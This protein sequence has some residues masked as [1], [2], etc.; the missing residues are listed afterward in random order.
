MLFIRL[1]ICNNYKNKEMR[2]I[3]FLLLMAITVTLAG[4]GGDDPISEEEFRTNELRSQY[5][6]KVLGSWYQERQDDANKVFE[7]LN[8]S[9]DGKLTGYVKW[10]RRT[11]VTVGGEEVWTDWAT[12][13]DGELNGTW[14][15]VWEKGLSWIDLYATL[16]G[17]EYLWYG[18]KFPFHEATEEYLDFESPFWRLNNNY[19]TI[20]E[21]GES[22][23]S[24]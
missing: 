15:L 7:Q 16:S 19:Y 5:N 14:S 20:Y 8:F 10:L 24:F 22:S 11:K 13:E 3:A 17:R 18:S 23:P 2:K 4:C 1:L 6:E 12:E 21:R 9:A